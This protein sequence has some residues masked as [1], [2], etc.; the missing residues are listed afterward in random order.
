MSGSYGAGKR[1]KQAEKNSERKDDDENAEKTTTRF[2]HF[3]C[4][5]AR[6]QR[7]N[8]EVTETVFASEVHS[9]RRNAA[10]KSILDY[11]SPK[12]ASGGSRV[13]S[14]DSILNSNNIDYNNT[15]KSI[16]DLNYGLPKN[17]VVDYQSNHTTPAR[18]SMAI[19]SDGEVVVFDDIDDNWQ[20][21]RL[22]LG[23]NNSSPGIQGNN[24]E[25]SLGEADPEDAHRGRMHP[26]PPGSSVGS[27]PSPAYH[28][29]ASDFFKVRSMA[30]QWRK[31]VEIGIEF[32]RFYADSC[33]F[34]AESC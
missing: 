31:S 6:R 9:V 29:N 24:L 3:R 15:P 17:C 11:D 20:G 27:T 4:G 7:T 1:K 30:W 14:Y 2:I 32:H 25:E 5:E 16:T 28:R 12:R 19:V 26:E 23:T 33:W 21:L 13:I 18:S 22:D 10:A 8:R 34:E